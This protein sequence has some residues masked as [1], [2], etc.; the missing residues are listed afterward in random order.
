MTAG[1]ACDSTSVYGAVSTYTYGGWPTQAVVTTKRALGT[2][3]N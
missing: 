3:D 2:D 1:T